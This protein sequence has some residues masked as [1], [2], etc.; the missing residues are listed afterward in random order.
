MTQRKAIIVGG[1]M[2]GLFAANMLYR[3]GWNVSVFERSPAP[4]SGR[5]TGIVTHAG[6]LALLRKAGVDTSGDLGVP[7][8]RRL[9]IAKSGEVRAETRF[10]QILMGWSKLYA[11]L[12]LALPRDAY[13]LDRLVCAVDCGGVKQSPLVTCQSGRT[14]TADVV[15]G[16]DG[17]RSTLREMLMPGEFAVAAPYVA[18]RG[19]ARIDTLSRAAQQQL[20]QA[21]VVVTEP[22]EEMV[23]YPVLG[24]DGVVYINFVWYRLVTRE[25]RV[26]LFSDSEGN[27]FP[28]GISPRAIKPAHALRA[29]AAAAELFHEHI[30]EVVEATPELLLQV[31]VDQ[32]ASCMTQGRVALIG[33][34]AFVARPHVGQGVTKAGGDAWAL[35]TCLSDP[36]VSVVDALQHYNALR[37]PV[38]VRA[39]QRS[40]E[41]G[42][43]LIPA[44]ETPPAMS[45][46][47]D[48]YLNANALLS[49]TA[50]ELPGLAHV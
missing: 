42:A 9:S 43:V 37:L 49:D 45:R 27:H 22:G 46:W 15:I 14:D 2:A 21:F 50:V 30:A 10:K 5:G 38:G 20:G 17:V 12:Y 35:T 26:D 48:H 11:L 34:A 18:W 31:I 16:A 6:M 36:R 25:E 8:T 40:R 28:Q 3:A 24:D 32:T 39:V 29:R 1:S 19:M 33:D 44:D 23:T 4:L 41:L 13:H 7:L 47:R